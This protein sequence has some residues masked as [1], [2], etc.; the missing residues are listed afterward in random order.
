MGIT[1]RT[2]SKRKVP[3]YRGLDPHGCNVMYAYA[4]SNFDAPRSTG[5]HTIMMNGAAI[6][7]TSKK[8]STV[9]VSTTAAG[10]LPGPTAVVPHP[11]LPWRKIL[12]RVYGKSFGG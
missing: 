4:D 11:P 9:D 6:V 5:G 3:K 10:A 12:I 8:H 7:N 2:N 1:D